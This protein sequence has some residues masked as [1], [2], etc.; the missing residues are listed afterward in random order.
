MVADGRTEATVSVLRDSTPTLVLLRNRSFPSAVTFRVTCFFLHQYKGCVEP[1][2][3][4]DGISPEFLDARGASG[5][6]DAW[7]HFI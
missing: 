6:K 1:L 2:Y 4:I 3:L 5:I 7:S